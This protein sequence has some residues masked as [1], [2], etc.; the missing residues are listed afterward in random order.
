LLFGTC[1]ALDTNITPAWKTRMNNNKLI[2]GDLR[3]KSA[4]TRHLDWAHH[5][6]RARLDGPSVKARTSDEL[7]DSTKAV[8]SG[9]TDDLATGAVGTP[10][11]QTS[12]FLLNQEQ[13]TSVEEGHARDRF[14]YTRYGNP[15]QWAVQ[16][17]LAALEGAQSALV[18]SSGMA[19]ITASVMALLDKGAHV[20][21]SNELY[22]GTY[23]LFNHEFPTMG[24]SVSYVNPTDLD[25][26]EK[27]IKPNTQILYFE[28]LTNPLLKLVDIKG[29]VAIAKKHR[30]R[31]VLDATFT[32]PIGCKPLEMGADLVIHSAS[33]YLNGHSDLIA[34]CVM[35][36]RKLVDM[37]WPRLLSYGSSMDPHAAFLLERGLKTLP[38]RMRTHEINA[39]ELANFLE[40]HGKVLD[41]YYPGASNH[42]QHELATQTLNNFGGMIAFVVKGGDE[43][44]LKLLEHLKL[45]KQATSLGGIESLISL[46]F[47][48][49][50]A[51]YTSGQRNEMGILPGCV[52]LSVG[53]EDYQD[54][55]QDFEQALSK[56]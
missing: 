3:S 26:I 43:A 18:F 7:H 46:P 4:V 17:K 28:T 29:L 8:H 55:I 16:E 51:G 1:Y 49:S 34:G 47:N 30:L 36:P 45:P 38:I 6:T 37:I 10:I 23:N 40:S 22:G 42:P 19:A 27:A 53:I 33:K 20:V 15:S 50:H 35:G 52:R 41:V 56:I 31:L 25:A 14:I 12:T 21:A 2:K 39:V 54:L 5:L 13:Y 32:T 9:T 11:F 48:T 24:L 44:A